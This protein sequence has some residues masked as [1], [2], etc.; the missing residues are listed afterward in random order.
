MRSL[1]A[2][3][4]LFEPRRHGA[5]QCLC[6]FAAWDARAGELRCGGRFQHEQHA[7]RA[8]QPEGLGDQRAGQ[9]AGVAQPGQA[10]AGAHEC[11]EGLT[12][13]A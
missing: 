5:E 8:T 10:Q 4:G 2:A 3:A 13:Q 9:R 12:A 1:P 11:V 7:L 6:V